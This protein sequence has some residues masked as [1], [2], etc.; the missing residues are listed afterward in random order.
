MLRYC[1]DRNRFPKSV[2]LKVSFFKLQSQ[3][4]LFCLNSTKKEAS[5]R[6]SLFI[7]DFKKEKRGQDSA[8]KNEEI[9]QCMN[10]EENQ[11]NLGI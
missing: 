8:I 7:S 10:Q 3:T 11:E 1:V 5:L 4:Q 9:F 6:F 2:C